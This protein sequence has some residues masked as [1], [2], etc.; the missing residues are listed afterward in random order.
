MGAA[1]SAPAP[2]G[3]CNYNNY[4]KA[5]NIFSLP[6]IEKNDLE[7]NDLLQKSRKA[8]F[9]DTRNELFFKELVMS[10][11]RVQYCTLPEEEGA[12]GRDI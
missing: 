9:L 4:K 11:Y 6:T 8:S 7:K 2:S 1:A 12:T 10:K 5:E 3:G